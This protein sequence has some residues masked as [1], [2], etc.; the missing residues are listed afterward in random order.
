MAKKRQRHEDPDLLNIID[1]DLGPE[2]EALLERGKTER[3]PILRGTELPGGRTR[4]PYART[5]VEITFSDED[6]LRR[7]VRLLRWS[8]DRLRARIDQLLLWEWN[9]S[10]REGMTIY[11]GVNW[12]DAEFFERRKDAFR[13]P[14]HEKFY[15]QFGATAEDFKMHH[16]I[17]GEVVG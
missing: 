6:D 8:D 2:L 15:S 7:C 4:P 5:F 3:V 16:E 17:E 1:E 12:Y 13:E 9:A 10:F 11:F 14:S